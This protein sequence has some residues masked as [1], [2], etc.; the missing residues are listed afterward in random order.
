MSVRVVFQSMKL[1]MPNTSLATLVLMVASSVNGCAFGFAT[2]GSLSDTSGLVLFR[3]SM[4]CGRSIKRHED[5]GGERVK[6]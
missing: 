2:L 6:S 4:A 5:Q 1:S 3:Y